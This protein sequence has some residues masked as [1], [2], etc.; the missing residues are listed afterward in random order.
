MGAGNVNTE[1]TWNEEGGSSFE[2]ERQDL[3]H[4]ARRTADK[5][6]G[7]VRSVADSSRTQL[8][9][10][11]GS[12]GRALRE[13]GGKLREDEHGETTSHYTEMLADRA[14]RVSRFLEEHDAGEL[15]GEVENVARK[16][17]LLFL[18]GCAAVGFVL[19]R[20]LKASSPGGGGE[21][22]MPL[23]VTDEG[24]ESREPGQ[25]RYAFGR[26]GLAG[27]RER[28]EGGQRRYESAPARDLT[29]PPETPVVTPV[30]TTEVIELETSGPGY[31]QP[32]IGTKKQDG[33]SGE[34]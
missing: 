17:P 25:E 14:D 10:Q 16:S 19:G 9:T 7:Q 3:K 27:E 34:R 12:I 28:Y 2:G 33:E 32:V 21:E 5:A 26:G 13:A 8:A 15:Y 6:R 30:V 18:G 29:T 24:Y 31:V 1:G 22:R 23:G 11:I 4:K 20:F